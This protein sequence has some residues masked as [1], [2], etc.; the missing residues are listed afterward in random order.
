MILTIAILLLM[1]IV[2]ISSR[3]ED[4]G[5]EPFGVLA[6]L[7]LCGPVGPSSASSGSLIEL[8]SYG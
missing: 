2:E 7:Y 8:I 1:A 3:G 4:P 5:W 6:V